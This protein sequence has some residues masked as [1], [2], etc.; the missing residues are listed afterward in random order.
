M[1]E[2]EEEVFCNAFTNPAKWEWFKKRQV[3]DTEK[4]LVQMIDIFDEG[5]NTRMLNCHNYEDITDFDL[6]FNSSVQQLLTTYNTISANI[7]NIFYQSNA[8]GPVVLLYLKNT[9]SS[10]ESI[11]YDVY[12]LTSPE[13]VFFTL[14]KEV[15]NKYIYGNE[16]QAHSKNADEQSVT[17]EKQVSIGLVIEKLK[18]EV[19][20]SKLKEYLRNGLMDFEYYYLDAIKFIHTCN[21]DFPLYEYWF[22]SYNFQNT[23]MYDRLGTFNE[24]HFKKELM[25]LCFMARMF[26]IPFE[27]LHCPLPEIYYLWERHF[28]SI[29]N[30]L[31]HFFKS[32]KNIS[33]FKSLIVTIFKYPS[34][35]PLNEETVDEKESEARF[36]LLISHIC[37]DKS[38]HN[39]EMGIVMMNGGDA[40]LR[41]AQYT[42][43]HFRSMEDKLKQGIPIYCSTEDVQGYHFINCL[44]YASLHLIYD[45]NK[46]VCLLRRDWENGNALSIFLQS[47]T[48]DNL[49]FI[50]QFGGIFFA[51]NARSAEYF[52]I[53]NALLQSLWHYSLLCKKEIY[54]NE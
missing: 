24:E 17:G 44:I 47:S 12:H 15:L 42:Y 52:R 50:D 30:S 37:K 10:Y 33:Q 22:W 3:H 34:S 38:A 13:F 1:I 32:S 4:V 28:K 2:K 49:Y 18:K 19:E 6:D 48:G 5:Y 16:I 53:R 36:N 23:S 45:K 31:D 41:H 54:F 46:Q 51:N 9:V 11:N 35:P 7:S 29:R 40:I 39:P 43:T 26:E 25:R 27:K 8:H 14:I 21:F 20:E